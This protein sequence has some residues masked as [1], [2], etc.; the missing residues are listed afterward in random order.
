MRLT[1]DVYPNNGPFS[2]EQFMKAIVGGI[3]L[4]CLGAGAAFAATL[5]NRDNKA[6]TFKVNDGGVISTKR[7][8]PKTTMYGLCT[9]NS[10]CEISIKGKTVKFN[11]DSRLKIERGKLGLE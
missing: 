3:C 11:S 1:L 7:I 8:G 10:R 5:S 9:P 2:K 6:Y 4:L